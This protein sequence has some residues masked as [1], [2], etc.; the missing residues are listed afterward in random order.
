MKATLGPT[1][2]M[3][4]IA[5]LS[6]STSTCNRKEY[7][8]DF[9]IAPSVKFKWRG[10]RIKEKVKKMEKMLFLLQIK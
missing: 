3:Q 7:L 8:L 1:K 10:C 2:E 9:D 6:T 5:S 4:K